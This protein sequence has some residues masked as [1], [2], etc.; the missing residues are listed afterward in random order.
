MDEPFSQQHLAASKE[1][2]VVVVLPPLTISIQALNKKKL[3][4]E[5]FSFSL[6][7]RHFRSR[8]SPES[9]VT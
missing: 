8:L 5:N 6:L 2:V 9:D 1:M 3:K 4:E 7:R